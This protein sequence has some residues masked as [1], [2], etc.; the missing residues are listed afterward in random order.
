VEVTLDRMPMLHAWFNLTVTR[1]SR[2]G[3]QTLA[4]RVKDL[5]ALSQ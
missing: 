3:H 4:R 1:S 5:F 2:R